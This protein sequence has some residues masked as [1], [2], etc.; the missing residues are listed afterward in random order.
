ME[1]SGPLTGSATGATQLE[2]MTK[3]ERPASKE[4]KDPPL[5]DIKGTYEARAKQHAVPT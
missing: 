3:P 1:R 5:L 4:L 2:T